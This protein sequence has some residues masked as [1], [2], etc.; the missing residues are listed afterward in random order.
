M[1]RSLPEVKVKVMVKNGKLRLFPP[2]TFTH[3]LFR[4]VTAIVAPGRPGTTLA[5]S[6]KISEPKYVPVTTLHLCL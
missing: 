2:I 4:I 5:K 1:S 3:D 6:M